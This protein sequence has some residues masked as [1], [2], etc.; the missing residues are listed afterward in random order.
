MSPEVFI[1]LSAFGVA[2]M[3]AVF[4]YLHAIV[5]PTV[6]FKTIGYTL[7]AVSDSPERQLL[8]LLVTAVMA[9]VLAAVMYGS[10]KTQIYPTSTGL[11]LLTVMLIF[12]TLLTRVSTN[13]FMHNFL[14]AATLF[15]ILLL[16]I[17]MSI[18][19]LMSK[20]TLGWKRPAT[21][22]CILVIILAYGV[23]VMYRI[24]QVRP[25][26]GIELFALLELLTVVSFALLLF[27]FVHV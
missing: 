13:P 16:M 14:A 19:I 24:M 26:E 17:A 12:G 4:S 1:V 8:G 21:V 22:L 23:A 25:T 3:Y 11:G 5:D 20:Q 9:F 10:R 15:T 27:I 2:A 7:S 18:D 6:S